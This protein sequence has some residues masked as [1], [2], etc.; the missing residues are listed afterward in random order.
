MYANGFPEDMV[1][2]IA[3]MYSLIGTKSP[4]LL[5]TNEVFNEITHGPP[6][7]LEAWIEL[8]KVNFIEKN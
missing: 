8:E 3:E 5:N 6:E 1:G 2:P 4:Y 7:C